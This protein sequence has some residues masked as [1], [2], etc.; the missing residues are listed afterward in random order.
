M[1]Q[2]DL[3]AELGGE[4]LQP[5]GATPVKLGERSGHLILEVMPEHATPGLGEKARV[6]ETRKEMRW[7]GVT[8]LRHETSLLR[9]L[10]GER[11]DLDFD[12]NVSFQ[13][14]FATYVRRW[15]GGRGLRLGRAQK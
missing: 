4:R 10:G 15:A 14:A 9:R 8:A 3:L 7:F 6:R 12:L 2:E 13:S 5:G 11:G 1:R